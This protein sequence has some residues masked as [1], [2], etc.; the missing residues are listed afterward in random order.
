M[1]GKTKLATDGSDSDITS[2]T[3]E[4][5]KMNNEITFEHYGSVF[6]EEVV[7]GYAKPDSD[8]G[9][10]KNLNLASKKDVCYINEDD[11]VTSKDG[12]DIAN[13][14]KEKMNGGCR[15]VDYL[16]NDGSTHANYMSDYYEGKKNC[17]ELPE[18]GLKN[19][20]K[21]DYRVQSTFRLAFK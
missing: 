17:D 13:A 20:C 5:V 1:Y 14:I 4:A 12:K 19:S 6:L 10:F 21:A 11:E 15:W 2:D 3:T 16:E 18:G 9:T 8:D 7:S